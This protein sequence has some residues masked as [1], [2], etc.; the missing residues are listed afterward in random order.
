MVGDN[1][2]SEVGDAWWK[3]R[4]WTGRIKDVMRRIGK[5][6]REESYVAK[7]GENASRQHETTLRHQQD[8][9]RQDADCD[10]T[11]HHG[12]GFYNSASGASEA[13]DANLL[14]ADEVFRTELPHQPSSVP[15][16]RRFC[17]WGRSASGGF[18]SSQLVEWDMVWHCSGWAVE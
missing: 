15:M 9:L 2:R 14:V 13:P 18:T 16:L 11:M 6:E 12:E 5:T 7:V 4:D 17:K 10:G 8:G 1:K 3:T